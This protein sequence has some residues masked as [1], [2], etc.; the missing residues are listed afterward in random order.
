MHSVAGSGGTTST[1]GPGPP[2][3]GGACQ[4]MH[5]L[6]RTAASPV[7]VTPYGSEEG[8]TKGCVVLCLDG[9][10]VARGPPAVGGSQSHVGRAPPTQ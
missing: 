6:C 7:A 2:W 4:R 8:P 3:E 1:A 10:P 5:H 9:C